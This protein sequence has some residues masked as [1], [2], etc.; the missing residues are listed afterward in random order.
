MCTL[1]K[2]TRPKSRIS[3]KTKDVLFRAIY[4]A[5]LNVRIDLK[6]PPDQDV[7]LAQIMHKIWAEQ[8]RVLGLVE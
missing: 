6:L 2:P 8:R 4:D 5:I 3:R 1:K 7:K